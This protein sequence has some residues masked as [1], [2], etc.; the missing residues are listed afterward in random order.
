MRR[1]RT[2]GFVGDGGVTGKGDAAAGAGV[3]VTGVTGVDADSGLLCSGCT[4]KCQN[5]IHVPQSLASIKVTTNA[6]ESIA[7][8]RA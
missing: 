1:R 3:G 2:L 8:E 5:Q 7:S 4:Q 6:S